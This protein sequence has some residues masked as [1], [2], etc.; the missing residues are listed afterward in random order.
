[1]K[2]ALYPNPD[3]DR[4]LRC[5]RELIS[6]L[7]APSVELYAEHRFSELL[8]GM[9]VRFAD[10]PEVFENARFVLSVGG[11]GTLL[12]A[13]YYAA[14]LGIPILGVN[15]GKFGYLAELEASELGALGPL[16]SGDMTVEER[17][18]LTA[19]VL[20]DGEEAACFHGLNDAVVSRGQ[21]SRLLELEL[22]CDGK[23]ISSYR[24]DGIVLA[25]P[26]GSTAYSL[27]AGGPI[28]EPTVECLSMVPI[29]NHALD[30][31]S[32]L[33]SPS[34]ELMILPKNA[35]ETDVLLWV[36]GREGYRLREDDRV[37]VRRSRYTTR[38][39][40]LREKSF[41]EILSQKLSE[42]G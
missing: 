36:D 32:V 12:R 17:M 4:E 28:I 39:V 7:A 14:P 41:Y 35:R 34:S 18:M 38:L 22:Y 24:G 6:R 8:S 33:F 40:K 27:S 26:T 31:R 29:C 30:S 15:L 3:K 9:G 11:D 25:T 10:T 2:I 23:T 16:L 37:L 1:M 21:V 19:C 5:T 42:R 20:R 13:S